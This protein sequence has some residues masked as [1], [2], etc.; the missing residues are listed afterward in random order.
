MSTGGTFRILI[1]EGLADQVIFSTK[2]LQKF[3]MKN[4][5][6]NKIE[7]THDV[8][9]HARFQPFCSLAYE[10][11]KV[12]HK[13][14]SRFNETVIFN[15]PQYGEYIHDIVVNAQV[16][17]V[18]SSL[19]TVPTVSN[20]PTVFNNGFVESIPR[21]G[22]EWDNTTEYVV[23][24]TPEDPHQ[25]GQKFCLVNIFGEKVNNTQYRNMVK[26][27]DYPGERL[28]KHVK[29]T[30]N[31]NI[32]DQYTNDAASVMRNYQVTKDKMIGYKKCIGQEYEHTS[33]SCLH[34]TRDNRGMVNKH[35]DQKTASE[36]KGTC[37]LSDNPDHPATD[38]DVPVQIPQTNMMDAPFNSA[39]C[40]EAMF[41]GLQT[42][43]LALSPTS[44][45]IPLQ[46]W[47]CKDVSCSFPSLSVP[48]GQRFIEMTLDEINNIIIETPYL[49]VRQA[50]FEIY[51]GNFPYNFRIE[52]ADRSLNTT[53]LGNYEVI[54]STIP[55]FKPG[56]L[57]G[58]ISKLHLYVNNIF[59][60]PEIQQI[61]LYKTHTTLIRATRYQKETIGQEKQVQ[62]QQISWPVEFV[63]FGFQPLWNTD[64]DNIYRGSD[65]C[66][67]THCIRT[68]P[69][70]INW[71]YVT[72]KPPVDSTNGDSN[73]NGRFPL[74]RGIICLQSSLNSDTYSIDLPVVSKLKCLNNAVV[75]T[76]QNTPNFFENILNKFQKTDG[77]T[78]LMTIDYRSAMP[79]KTCKNLDEDPS[80][81]LNFSRSREYI[82]KWESNYISSTNPVIF[83]LAQCLNILK[84]DKGSAVIRYNT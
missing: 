54:Y 32:L 20:T 21:N 37:L 72:F 47:F 78:G 52:G 76:Q 29:I 65:W 30:I 71:D 58:S 46:F 41:N 74:N 16:S 26:Y 27:C 48:H 31:G 51:N 11:Q 84:V 17:G 53:Q 63:T 67:Y 38:T 59:I 14:S 18:S 23:P 64:Q 8:Y 5:N 77:R 40:I 3:L 61:L 6:L 68:S 80:G 55:Y 35:L 12:V 13:G 73:Y 43:K 19:Q 45:W 49:F 75:V 10:Y 62:L 82:I 57:T 69:I 22:Y 1:N 83:L 44:F 33:K 2:H 4:P 56:T 25:H 39:Q 9:V 81:H 50:R 36:L 7:Q 34:I 66:K 28:I 60:M 79:E 24:T 70:N 42:P 15:L